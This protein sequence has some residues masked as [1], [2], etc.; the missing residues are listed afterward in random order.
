MTDFPSVQV[1]VPALL[2]RRPSPAGGLGLQHRGPP[3][4]HHPQELPAGRSHTGQDGLRIGAA[5][6][7][8][9]L[10]GHGR[11]RLA[12]T[13]TGH[14]TNIPNTDLTQVQAQALRTLDS[15]LAKD[16]VIVNPFAG[17]FFLLALL[18]LWTI[19]TNM[20]FVKRAPLFLSFFPL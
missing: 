12:G 10:D 3:A 16:A 14:H 13:H 2:R 1:S 17:L 7:N 15:F 8:H 19:K 6:S 4:A 5:T 9:V 18:F 20:T 11:N